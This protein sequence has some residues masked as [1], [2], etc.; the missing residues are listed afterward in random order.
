M[1]IINKI[2]ILNSLQ[3]SL[4][5]TIKILHLFGDSGENLLLV[6]KDDNVYQVITSVNSKGKD[7][8]S[9]IEDPLVIEELCDKHVI[10]FDSCHDF[11]SICLL[12]LTANGDVYQWYYHSYEHF[13]K[14]KLINN[15]LNGKNVADISC[16][17]YHCLILTQCGQVFAFGKNYFGQIGNNCNTNQ[18]TPIKLEQ[19]ANEKVIA[20]S[21]G[22]YHSVA[23]TQSGNV[24]SWG[25]N[26]DGQLGIGNTQH[27]NSPTPVRFGDQNIVIDRISCGQWHTLFLSHD[28]D[29]YAC[30]FNIFGQLGCTP[31]LGIYCIPIKINT[32]IKFKDIAASHYRDLSAALSTD[33]KCFVWGKCGQIVTEPQQTD[34]TCINEAFVVYSRPQI[35]YKSVNLLEL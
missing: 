9:K 35:T 14:P 28:G 30:G 17:G 1:A 31:R 13:E 16:G 27:Q 12:A 21:C 19:F 10:K 23:L 11:K 33:G 4:V 26:D 6:T 20:I 15:C 7:D 18:L 3:L 25:Y 2:N 8:F 32:Y 24:F 29:I 22:L 34:I 5:E